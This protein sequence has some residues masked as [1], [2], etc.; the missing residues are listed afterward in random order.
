M[1]LHTLK[2]DCSSCCCFIGDISVAHTHEVHD[3]LAHA[4]A[5]DEVFHEVGDEGEGDAHQRDHEVAHS[6]GEQEQVGDRPHPPVP[7]QHCDD[8]AVAQQAEEEDQAVEENPDGPVDVWETH[9]HQLSEFKLPA[10]LTHH[11]LTQSA[12]LLHPS[13]KLLHDIHQIV[14]QALMATVCH[15]SPLW[16]PAAFSRLFQT[17]AF[18]SCSCP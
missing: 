9:K 12:M 5:E 1:N 18:L 15:F 16:A 13:S 10:I 2:P 7:H 3:Q 8:E 11:L 14:N 17:D 4:D 6:Q